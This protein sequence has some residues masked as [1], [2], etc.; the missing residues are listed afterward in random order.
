MIDYL[1]Y[2]LHNKERQFRLHQIMKLRMSPGLEQD[3]G[4][5]FMAGAETTTQGSGFPRHASVTKSL[6]VTAL[7][8]PLIK[9]TEQPSPACCYISPRMRKL[10]SPSES[11]NQK[12]F[13]FSWASPKKSKK[14]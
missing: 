8:F 13:R 4:N 6:N 2:D 5:S 1:D 12:K 9:Q 11:I 14:S 10:I 7:N 3:G